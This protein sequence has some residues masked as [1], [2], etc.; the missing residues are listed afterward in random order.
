MR[1]ILNVTITYDTPREKI[2]EAVQVL[3]DIFEEDG[4]REPI[5]P[6]I[7][8]DYLAPRVFFND[9]NSDSLNI[10][11][12]YWYVPPD[13]WAYMEHAHRVNL[14]IFEE[15][16]RAGIE[17]AFPTQTVYLAGDPKRELALKLLGK[18]LEAPNVMP[19]S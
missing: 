14:R 5:H 12:I 7:G 10:F 15:F 3:R 1:R 6:T 11:V 17:F 19:P 16:E 9:F 18:D 2:E 13:W 8:P 4:I